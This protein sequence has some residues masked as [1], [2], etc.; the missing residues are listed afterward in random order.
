MT[1]Y[2]RLCAEL[3][4]DDELSTT[5]GDTKLK[6]EEKLVACCQWNNYRNANCNVP[7]AVCYLCC[8]KLE[9]C[10]LFNETIAI[11]QAKLE[12]L[13]HDIEPLE[14][15]DETNI[16]E[17]EFNVAETSLDIFVEPLTL[18]HVVN[19]EEKA[20]IDTTNENL[21]E[22]KHHQTHECDICGKSFTTSYNL[23]VALFLYLFSHIFYSV[24]TFK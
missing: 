6:I 13:F 17:D 1:T 8:E 20:V 10:W 5:I 16:E 4:T 18:P 21:D 22:T 12:E 11:A 15:K 24:I 7:D 2:C 3:K 23:T 19:D 9:K 14:V